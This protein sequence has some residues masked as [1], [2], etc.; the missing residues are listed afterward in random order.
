M[1]KLRIYSISDEYIDYLRRDRQLSQVSDPKEFERSH[2]RKYLGVV[3]QSQNYK[4]YIPFSSPK[5]SDYILLPDGTSK[6]RNSILPI[7]RMITHDT[8]S[9]EVE[10]KGTLK[11]CDMIPV[12]DSELIPYFI[13][14]ETDIHYKDIIQK[15]YAFINSNRSMIIKNAQQLYIQKTCRDELFADKA[16]PKYLDSTIDFLYAE[17]KCKE[18]MSLREKTQP[19][20]IRK[21][22]K[23]RLMEAQNLVEKSENHSKTHY[24]KIK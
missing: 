8:K 3:I 22:V 14:K 13:E 4:Y 18:F 7:I 19:P 2:T 21:S 15:E 12:P 9:G 1:S 23:D 16:A 6:I 10:L 17:Q 20:A 11:I 5:K 24:E